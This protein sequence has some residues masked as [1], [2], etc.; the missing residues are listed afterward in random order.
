[1]D[2][3]HGSDLAPIFG[4]L[5]QS[6]TLYDIKTPVDTRNGIKSFYI[7]II[8]FVQLRFHVFTHLCPLYCDV[9]SNTNTVPVFI[10]III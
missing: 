10:A 2:S 8:I 6:K 1:M 7:N 4:D 9:T 3:A 5:S